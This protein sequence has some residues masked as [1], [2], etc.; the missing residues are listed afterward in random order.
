[1]ALNGT[2]NSNAY[3]GR[4]IQ[5]T[6]TATQNKE[7]NTSTIYWT[8]KGAGGATNNYYMAGN[9][10]VVINSEQVY[11]SSSRIQLFNG[12]T[13]ASGSKT[14]N[15]NNNGD[16]SLQISIEAGIYTYAVNC[17]GSDSFT[18]DNIPRATT[19]VL[20]KTTATMGESITITL[21]RISSNFTHDVAIYFGDKSMMLKEDVATSMSWT[22]PKSLA[23]WIPN[24][25]SMKAQITAHTY[26]G[27]TLI[28][29]KSADITINISSDIKPSISE[30]SV[31][32]ATEI[33]DL[34]MYIQNMSKLKVLT[35]AEG[36]YNSTIKDI[37]VT[38]ESIDY[39]G[40]DVTTGTLTGSGQVDVNVVV[41]DSRSQTATKKQTIT[42]EAYEP[43]KIINF[44]ARRCDSAGNIKESGTHALVTY[45][46]EI[47]PLNNKNA[48]SAVVKYGTGENLTELFSVDAYSGNSTFVSESLFEL[49]NSY[50]VKFELSDSFNSTSMT[51]KISTERVPLELLYTGLGVSIGKAA[52]LDE[53]FEVDLY[54][55]F[56]KAV[57]FKSSPTFDNALT[58]TNGFTY[59]PMQISSGDLNT[60]TLISGVWYVS[61]ADNRP[62]TS[63]GFLIVVV[64]GD[65]SIYQ[66]FITLS[67]L[68]YE[69]LKTSS[70][71]TPW[72]GWYYY[73]VQGTQMWE[74]VYVGL[75]GSYEA[76][77]KRTISASYTT[78][79]NGVYQMAYD[80]GLGLQL[81][82]GISIDGEPMC[83]VNAT[84]ANEYIL[85]RYIGFT[86]SQTGSFVN[87]RFAKM[88]QGS[89][90]STN[91]QVHVIGKW[92]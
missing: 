65:N 30:L 10:K 14:I 81:P 25:S 17:T 7:E 38:V 48:K 88:T 37:K 74:R 9:F 4:Y 47:K 90:I 3:D 85:C 16:A 20:S 55:I 45:E 24:A 83:F 6:W 18:L 13:V 57:K 8:L 77:G 43:P 33:A 73:T 39:K 2:V 26:R 28:G 41:T 15:H 58:L 44:N 84:A 35:T 67:G 19:P 59:K 36:I 49:Y 79:T 78:L 91:A 40:A 89:S 80:V 62:V 64:N 34:G 32:E 1:M 76:Y 53:T 75:D 5:L 69:R 12:T 27:T 86:S 23:Q 11:Y 21:N 54:T 63:S 22:I 68:T 52:E 72:C 50:E 82:N 66:K 61:N 60:Y 87:V 56:N 31:S 70:G 46:F 92:K 71:W 29:S 51:V 42:V